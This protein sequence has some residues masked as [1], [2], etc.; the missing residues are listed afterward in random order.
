[1]GGGGGGRGVLEVSCSFF[2]ATF[3]FFLAF[4]VATMAV[5]TIQRDI[6]T[7]W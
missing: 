6:G 3:S 2:E 7:F 4:F 5:Y 1:M